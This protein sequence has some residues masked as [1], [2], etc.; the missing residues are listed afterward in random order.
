MRENL[1][2]SCNIGEGYY[3]KSDDTHRPD[4]FVNCYKNLE[5][6]YLLNNVY[7]PCYLS[8][9]SCSG[10]GDAID[11]NCT[12]CKATYE[13]KNDYEN[14]RNCYPHCTHYYYYDSN[15]S[16]ICTEDSNCPP[17]Y[18][19]LINA[20]KRCIDNCKNDNLYQ[21]EYQNKCYDKCPSG[22]E[23]SINDTYICNEIIAE[24]KERCKLRDKDFKMN[25]IT[26]NIINNLTVDYVNEYGNSFD[27]VSKQ[28]NKIYTIFIYKDIDCLKKTANEAPQIDFGKC[29]EKIKNSYNITDELIITLI[30]KIEEDSTNPSTS[31]YFSN[32]M[33]GELLNFSDICS[34]ETIVIQEDVL[35]II[36]KL[37]E[38][39]E[40]YIKYLTNQGIDV[41]NSSDE[42]Y[43]DLCFN[44]ESPNGKD[45]PMKD[46][47]SSFY[48]NVTLCDKGCQNKGV[49]LNSMKAKCEC[50]FGNFINSELLMDNFYGQAIAE[51][52]D[53][54]SS[55]NIVVV[56]CVMKLF[57]IERFT[58]CT[59]GYIVFGL[60]F[61]QLIVIAKFLFSGLYSIRKYIF[62]LSGLYETYLKKNQMQMNVINHAPPKKKFI[63]N[64]RN[65][66]TSGKNENSNS[67]QSSENIHIVQNNNLKKSKSLKPIFIG[68]TPDLN[69]NKK[70]TGINRQKAGH[71]TH[72]LR[73]P[74]T[75]GRINKYSKK[76][77][78][79]SNTESTNKEDEDKLK[80]IKDILSE[81]FD[82]TDF[83]DVYDKDKRTF[84]QYFCEKFKDNQIFINAF[85]I[86]ETLKPRALKCLILIITIELY[87]V[88]TALFYNEDYLSE[89]FNSEGEDGFF[90]FVPRRINEFIYTSAVSGIITYLMGYFFVE[91]LKVKKIFLRNKEEIFKIKFELSVLVT[92]IKNKFT[93]LII[94]SILLSILCFIYISC[95]NIVYPYIRGEWIKSSIFILILMQILN[96]V[97][98]FL[99]C[100]IRYL[101][102]KYNSEK[103]F[104]LSNW[105]S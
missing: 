43:N 62:S 20:K 30:N 32:P 7:E 36:E 22:A 29:Y 91:E 70:K 82:E 78:R 75:I 98:T 15:N 18:N 5:G 28:G 72:K 16:Y 38:K 52:M 88:I 23:S 79:I 68:R 13:T 101:A 73:I 45:V 60:L 94:F 74:K 93:S 44:Y 24:E 54:I 12:K 37:D 2:E 64:L 67:V 46:R 42:F 27:Y 81:S 39:K 50:V 102:L 56:K 92:N 57:D 89:L 8:C 84:C 26:S 90:D 48:P 76:T 77:L 63:A 65:K 3:P 85:C 10:S 87:F 104:K 55:F 49:D 4:G 103:I 80:D 58:K 33:N 97:F 95:F 99:H 25:E 47:I 34:E 9:K 71:K 96:L 6:Y 51:A 21:Y 40:T 17:E 14:D 83:D 1:C 59:G 61:G 66:I 53:I 105:L 31:V 35:S 11:N 69:L 86:H 41:F 100:C 19:K